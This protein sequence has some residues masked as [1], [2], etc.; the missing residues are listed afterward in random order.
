MKIPV[1]VYE[2]IDYETYN[3]MYH[4]SVPGYV[5]VMQRSKYG[6]GDFILG[7]TFYRVSYHS[8]CRH[9]WVKTTLNGVLDVYL[10]GRFQK[11]VV[12]EVPG[13]QCTGCGRAR[14]V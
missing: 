5:P 10:Q 2:T 7:A 6:F 11:R 13:E 4:F 14:Y 1:K 8:G 9:A 12:N 3:S